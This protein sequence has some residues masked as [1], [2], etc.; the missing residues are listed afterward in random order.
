MIFGGKLVINLT[1]G[2]NFPPKACEISI[3]PVASGDDSVETETVT[4]VVFT[5][6]TIA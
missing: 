4:T 6:Y 2:V 5:L 3:S 1:N